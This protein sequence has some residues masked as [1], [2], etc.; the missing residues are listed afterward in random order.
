MMDYIH[1]TVKDFLHD[2]SFR[3]WTVSPDYETDRFWETWLRENPDRRPTVEQARDIILSIG[4]TGHLP[5]EQDQAE[6]W[7]RIAYS[8]RETPVK[9]S[10]GA[11]RYAA[12]VLGIFVLAAGWYVMQ[13][14]KR[15]E[16]VYSTPYGET[17]DIMLPDSSAV[18]LNANS[19]LTFSMNWNGRR[20]VWLEG[21]GFFSVTHRNNNAPFYVHTSDVDVQVIGTSFNVNTRRI[22]T[23]VVLSNGA[24]KLKLNGERQED[25][26][27]KP[28]EMVIYS[29]KTNQLSRKRV[30]PAD[31]YAW[32]DNMLIFNETPIAEVAAVLNDNLGINVNIEGQELQKE[33]F[34]G[35][36]P[37]SDVEIFFR[38]LS[39]SLH[40]DIEKKD[41]TSY[42]IRRRKN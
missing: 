25:V 10:S 3:K 12:V 40:V 39:R 2:E 27:M 18:K 14:G 1:Y 20:D 26:R 33:L 41:N 32:R 7:G 42:N 15:S 13:S 16:M 21:E 30:N 36:I 31:Y 4:T 23:R 8:I 17:R 34:T 6:V 5:T 22:M 28:G 9:R 19:R 11:W 37:M 38:T 35:S 24:V 29:T